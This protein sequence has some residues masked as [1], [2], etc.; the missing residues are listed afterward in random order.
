MRYSI[1]C[2]NATACFFALLIALPA[3]MVVANTCRAYAQAT[4][5]GDTDASTSSIQSAIRSFAA[6]HG[7][8]ENKLDEFYAA[9]N[10]RP[11]WTGSQEASRRAIELQAALKKADAQGLDPSA[12]EIGSPVSSERTSSVGGAVSYDVALTDA[13]LHYA[14][15]VQIGRVRPDAIYRDVQL[16]KRQRES[17]AR[18]AHAL[19]A[20]NFDSFMTDRKSVV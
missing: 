18:I 14:R 11:A 7:R 12:Y 8:S 2:A 20:E 17:V 6:A 16:P 10:Y 3:A 5:E 4:E 13:L 9:R 1:G 15:D 19:D